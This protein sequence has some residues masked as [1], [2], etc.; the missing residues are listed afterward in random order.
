MNDWYAEGALAEYCLTQPG[1]HRAQ[2]QKS[3]AHRSRHRPHLCT[4][5]VAGPDRSRRTS[6]SGQRVLI[7][8][9]S[10]GVGVFAV[11]LARDRGAHVIATASAHN[12]DFVKQLGADEFIDYKSQRFE[13][14]VSDIDVVFD[15]VGGETF[16]ALFRVLNPGGRIITIAASAEAE[17]AIDERK[18][19]AFFIVEPNQ[20]QLIEVAKLIDAGK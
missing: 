16:D 13:E 15:G 10:G 1:E 8:G 6:Q 12:R 19:N 7:H 11:Q 18:K 20:S 17:A 14:I 5:R 9:A 4:H 3:H 2:T